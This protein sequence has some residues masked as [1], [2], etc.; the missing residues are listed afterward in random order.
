MSVGKVPTRSFGVFKNKRGPVTFVS[1][2]ITAAAAAGILVYYNIEKEEQVKQVSK[3][4]VT[5]GKPALGGPWVL[6]DH[7]GIP[8]TDA[9]YHGK[10]CL[11]YFG[12]THCPDICPAEL[13]KVAK[14]L[15]VLD[16]KKCKAIQPLFISV[17]P[18]RDSVGQLKHYA[19]DFHKD[20]V[21][22]TG[23]K[24]QVAVAA[25]AYRVYFSKA[26]DADLESDEEYLVDHSI[27]L[28]LVSPE[29]EFLEFFTQR[30][31]VKDIVDKIMKYVAND[32][33]VQK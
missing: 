3:N 29:G 11:Y 2:T 13:V 1:L 25:K 28:Y 30:M 5:V 4:V 23:T 18:S 22:L 7:N 27:V 24:D 31:E 33:T 9:S 19:Q 6:V 17:D 21:Y 12:F 10:Y 20:V 8:R 14:V 26:V 15:N 32:P 16:K